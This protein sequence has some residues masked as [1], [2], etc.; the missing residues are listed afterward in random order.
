MVGVHLGVVIA[1]DRAARDEQIAAAM[2]ADVAKR[3]AFGM[4]GHW[5]CE[6]SLCLGK[7]CFAHRWSAFAA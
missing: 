7:R 3:D 2:A 4:L 1:M 5:Q 6:L